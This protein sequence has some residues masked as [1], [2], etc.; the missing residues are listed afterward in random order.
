MGRVP[1]QPG[2]VAGQVHRERRVARVQQVA[3]GHEVGAADGGDDPSA[4][5][6]ADQRAVVAAGHR[7]AVLGLEGV[8]RAE[9]HRAGPNGFAQRAI[10]A[11]VEAAG[12]GYLHARQQRLAGPG[13]RFHQQQVRTDPRQPVGHRVGQ[14]LALCHQDQRV[15]ARRPFDVGDGVG[16]DDVHPGVAEQLHQRVGAVRAGR[17]GVHPRAGARRGQV[18]IDA[19][20]DGQHQQ[21]DDH[22]APRAP[23]PGR[24]LG[25]G[26]ADRGHHRTCAHDSGTAG[27]PASA[28]TPCQRDRR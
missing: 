20:D 19:G 22:P 3:V 18:G 8:G 11:A 4:V 2:A 13:R 6:E 27:R 26:I 24:G 21:G 5:P 28:G 7:P 12:A 14:V 9:P 10:R 25:A 15:R 16:H 17:R 23:A 1:H